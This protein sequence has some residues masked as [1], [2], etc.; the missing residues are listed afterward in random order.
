MDNETVEKMK[1]L[2]SLLDTILT[3]INDWYE[4]KSLLD[5]P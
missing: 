3:S 1:K 2:V 4:N 5:L